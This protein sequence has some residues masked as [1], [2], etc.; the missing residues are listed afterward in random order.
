MRKKVIKNQRQDLKTWY[1]DQFAKSEFFHQ[2]LHEWGLLTIATKIER[3]KGEDFEWNLNL[4]GISPQAWNKVIHRGIKPVIV[5]ANPSILKK[6]R[7]AVGYYRMLA[8]VSQ[9]SMNRVKLSASRYE[10]GKALPEK[11]RRPCSRREK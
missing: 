7:G 11:G 10:S 9:K 8:M 6:I 5:F 3:S 2:K 1:L 4:L